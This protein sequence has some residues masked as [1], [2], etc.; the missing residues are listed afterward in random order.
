MRINHHYVLK[1]VNPNLG[2]DM[3]PSS[4]HPFSNPRDDSHRHYGGR[5]CARR[6]ACAVDRN[7]HWDLK[8]PYPICIRMEFTAGIYGGCLVSSW[9]HGMLS[10][11]AARDKGESRITS[12]NPMYNRLVCAFYVLFFHFL[13]NR[14]AFTAVCHRYTSSLAVMTILLLDKTNICTF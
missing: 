12:C 2:S 13:Y 4:F 3:H 5:E 10:A 6:Q 9:Q 14:W 8:Y 1:Q 7:T 11:A